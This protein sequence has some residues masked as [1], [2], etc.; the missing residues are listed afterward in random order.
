MELMRMVESADD[1]EKLFN[2]KKNEAIRSIQ[3][4]AG[5]DAD[6]VLEKLNEKAYNERTLMQDIAEF[7]EITNIMSE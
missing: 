6:E 2:E 4:S 7:S 5:S 3:E 1:K